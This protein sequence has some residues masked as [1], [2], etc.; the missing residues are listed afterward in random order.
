MGK[1]AGLSLA[2]E[3]IFF[4]KGTEKNGDRRKGDRRRI[5]KEIRAGLRAQDRDRV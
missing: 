1:W 2:G 5:G 3:N 4:V